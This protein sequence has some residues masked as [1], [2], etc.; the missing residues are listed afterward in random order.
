LVLSE[1]VEEPVEIAA[2]ALPGKG[3]CDLLVTLL[4]GTQT[5]GQ[6]V[7]VSEVVWSE[8]LTLDYREAKSV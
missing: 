7:G 8:W 2:S 1:P 6:S 3:L 4:E 5:F